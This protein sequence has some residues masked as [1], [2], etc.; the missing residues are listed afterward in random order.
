M[1]VVPSVLDAVTVHAEGALCTRLASVP[2]DKGRLP[3]QVRIEGLPLGLRTGSLRAAV[4]KG[5]Q[6]LQVR[7]IRP[8]F[9][10]RLP[11]ETDI[12]AAQRALEDAQEKLHGLSAELER[13]QRDLQS[14]QK[15]KPAFPPRKKE[16]PSEPRESALTAL[17]SLAG[18]VDTELAALHARHLELERQ[19]R[20]A[21]E[22]V[23]LRRRRLEESSSAVRGQ[24]AQLYRAAVLTLSEVGPVDEGAQL[25]LEYA[26]H[27]AR[28]VPGY[29][30]RMPRSL[31]GGTLNM[32]ASII[33]LTGEDWSN[34]RLSLSTADLARRADVPELKA[35]RI[36]RHQPPP[37][38]SGWREPPPG[39]DELFSGYDSARPSPRKPAPRQERTRAREFP[40]PPPAEPMPQQ[41]PYGSARRLRPPPRWRRRRCACPSPCAPWEARPRPPKWPRPR[42]PGPPC[43]CAEEPRP[44]QPGSTASEA[45]EREHD[46]EAQHARR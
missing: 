13:V 40:M 43:P 18:F 1:L 16:E 19:H 11:P 46:E 34:V 9:D 23:E 20:D 42:W 37:A 7:D 31:D 36:G 27:G 3:V 41:A 28:W 32:R 22:E 33:Q 25:A 30:L 44:L 8:A 39:L 35:L 38:R 17:L 5:P 45:Q 26:V 6:G 21:T 4:L 12:P 2:F 24:R 29:D 15:L 10:V 14:L